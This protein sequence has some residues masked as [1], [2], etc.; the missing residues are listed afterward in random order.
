VGLRKK[1]YTLPTAHCPLPTE[2]VAPAVADVLIFLSAKELRK[3]RGVGKFPLL[4]LRRGAQR[5]GLFN[6]E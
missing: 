2:K 6:D 4:I 5:G 3:M 1:K